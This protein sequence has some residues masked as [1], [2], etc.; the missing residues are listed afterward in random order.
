MLQV[1][2]PFVF[3]EEEV[4]HHLCEVVEAVKK[5]MD[6]VSFPGESPRVVVWRTPFYETQ[7]NVFASL[8]NVS[9]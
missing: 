8:C 2:A 1:R 5:K 6:G 3:V 9:F 7:V 4:E